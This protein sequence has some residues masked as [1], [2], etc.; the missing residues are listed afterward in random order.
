[1]IIDEREHIDQDDG[2]ARVVMRTRACCEV[3]VEQCPRWRF[4]RDAGNDFS[5]PFGRSWVLMCKEVKDGGSAWMWDREKTWMCSVMARSETPRGMAIIA[6]SGIG[7]RMRCS[8]RTDEGKER[9][10]R[11]RT[12]SASSLLLAAEFSADTS[13]YGA[14]MGSSSET[15]RERMR[16]VKLGMEETRT[17]SCMATEP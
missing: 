8:V 14:G 16:E 6:R 12:S 1:M 15:S 13:R 2:P 11:T 3:M 4:L 7:V 5:K 17:R 10:K 9:R